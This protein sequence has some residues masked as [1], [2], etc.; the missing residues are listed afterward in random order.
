M[1]KTGYND[2]TTSTNPGFWSQ[3]PGLCT[4]NLLTLN[5]VKNKTTAGHATSLDW[6]YLPVHAG[7][8][9]IA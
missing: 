1:D 7:Y 4:S 5:S 9:M 2:P 3:I 8:E 6:L